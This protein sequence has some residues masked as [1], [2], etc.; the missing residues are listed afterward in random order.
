L[1]KKT[2]IGYGFALTLT[3]SQRERGIRPRGRFLWWR[4]CRERRLS[5]VRP[6]RCCA[7]PLQGRGILREKGSTAF[8]LTLTLSQRERGIRP[9]GRFLW[10]RFCRERSLSGVRPPRCCAPPL[11]GRGILR[12]KGSTAFALTLTL[13]QRERGIRPWGRFLWWREGNF[14]GEGIYSFCPHPNPLPEG[15]GDPYPIC[16]TQLS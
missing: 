3:L 7:P 12:E 10:W 1:N 16:R 11:Q 15:E 5:G 2:I 8:A 4:F 14:E 6:P 9:W 13:S